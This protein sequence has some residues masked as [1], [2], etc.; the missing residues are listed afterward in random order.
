MYY[1]S[2]TH[3]WHDR[4]AFIRRH[5]TNVLSSVMVYSDG[6]SS[7][8]VELT[9]QFSMHSAY[10]EEQ[11]LLGKTHNGSLVTGAANVIDLTAATAQ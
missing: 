1:A 7:V 6:S 3:T 9:T 8:M 2:G 4:Q 10:A 5:V 11:G